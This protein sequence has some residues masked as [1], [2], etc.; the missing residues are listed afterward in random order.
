MEGREGKRWFR[1]GEREDSREALYSVGKVR[2]GNESS[3]NPPDMMPRGRGSENG[4]DGRKDQKRGSP[5]DLKT[6]KKKKYRTS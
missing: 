3:T 2:E 5:S 6:G 4:A 1:K